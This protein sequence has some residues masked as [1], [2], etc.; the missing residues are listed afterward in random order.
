[1]KMEEKLNYPKKFF[2]F[3]SGKS[4]ENKEINEWIENVRAEVKKGAEY[5]YM[6]SGN[7]IVIA[8]D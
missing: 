2:S 5:S 7:T 8:F 1:N 3:K 6:S 4:V